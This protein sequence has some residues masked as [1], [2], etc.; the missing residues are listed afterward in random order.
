MKVLFATTNPAKIE[1]YGKELERKGIKILTL[2]DLDV[3]IDVEEN[4]KDAVENATIKAKAYYEIAKIP[5]ISIDDSLFLEGVS[6]E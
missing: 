2:K 4:G 3:K 1:Y 5:T 6:K